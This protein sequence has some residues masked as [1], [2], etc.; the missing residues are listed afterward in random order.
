MQIIPGALLGVGMI[1]VPE[2]CRWLVQRERLADAWKSLTWIR[3]SQDTPVQEEMSEIVSTVMIER[4]QR[5]SAFL[6]KVSFFRLTLAFTIMVGQVCTGA[7]ALAYFSP[8][9][10][11][12]VV[13]EGTDN[14]LI[15]GIFGAIKIVSCGV[16]IFFLSERVG[17]RTSFCGGAILM[18]ACLLCVA[19]VDKLKP[20]PGDGVV[21]SAGIAVIALIYLTIIIYNMSWGP[22]GW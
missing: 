5:R 6:S 22:L 7:N 14:L 16:F 1:T 3:A 19:I 20:P 9:Y 13:G 8:Q 10:F 21:S 17:R 2:S 4:Q 12:L 15:S 18:S 11:T